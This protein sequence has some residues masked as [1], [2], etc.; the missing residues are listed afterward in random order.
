M[1]VGVVEKGEGEHTFG[2]LRGP[3]WRGC[4]VVNRGVEEGRWG[5]MLCGKHFRCLKLR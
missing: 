3:L 5:R 4:V 1:L 2:V